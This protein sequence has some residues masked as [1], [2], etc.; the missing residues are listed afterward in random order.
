MKETGEGNKR[1][2]RG[3][4]SEIYADKSNIEESERGKG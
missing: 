2:V 4:C 1:G 3:C